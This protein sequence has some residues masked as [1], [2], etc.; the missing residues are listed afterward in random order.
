MHTHRYGA[1]HWGLPV[2]GVLLAGGL[3]LVLVAVA[4]E[5]AVLRAGTVTPG[6]VLLLVAGV[7]AIVTARARVREGAFDRKL[8]KYSCTKCGYDP[9]LDEVEHGQSIPCPQCG[10]RIYA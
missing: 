10:K 2:T 4:V 3:I 9:H 7:L 6:V 5:D 8:H 1:A